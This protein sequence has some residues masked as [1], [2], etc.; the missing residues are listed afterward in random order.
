MSWI[1][2]CLAWADLLASTTLAGGIVHAVL[3]EEPSERGAGILRGATAMLAIVLLAEI[4]FNT[5]RMGAVSGIGGTELLRDVLDMRW[6]RLWALRA[7]GVTL[8]A[9]TV[10]P[11]RFRFSVA[12]VA[13]GWLGLRSLQGHAGANDFATA[14]ADWLHLTAVSLWL[15][16]L[17]QFSVNDEPS[18]V[19]LRRL[20]SIATVAVVVLI[21]SGAYG[22]LRHVHSAASLLHSRY[23]QMLLIKLGLVLP[24][25]TL[26]ARNHFRLS[27]RALSDD[28]G[29]AQSLRAAICAELVLGSVVL[30]ASAWLGWLPM[31]HS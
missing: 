24:L 10:G 27:P 31:P 25:L 23:G 8:F 17:L 12:A 26:G 18:P 5:Y 1:E 9:V 19:S 2:L 16:A 30:A 7:A 28:A 21:P 13:I 4:A 14:A 15:G 3:V 22:A 11:G 20:R 29:A 6:T